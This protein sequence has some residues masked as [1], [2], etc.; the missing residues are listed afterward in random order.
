MAA[1]DN[2]KITDSV[3]YKI[4]RLSRSLL[5]AAMKSAMA[6]FDL[7]VPEIRVL[8]VISSD[9]PLAST[10][11]VDISAMDK[12]LVSRALDKLLDRRLV[13]VIADPRDQRKYIWTLS[14]S[15]A[16]LAARIHA[17]RQKRQARFLACLSAD[18]QQIFK[19]MLD[20]LYASS[21]AASVVE[22]AE[23]VEQ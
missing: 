17:L 4:H 5:K 3:L 9:A 7:T 16:N 15:G 22:A 23:I 14:R 21:E 19:N 6:N 20:R 8:S 11:V 10:A 18:E 1:V 13:R 12:A 2:Y